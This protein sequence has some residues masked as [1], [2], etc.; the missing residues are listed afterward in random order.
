MTVTVAREAM[1]CDIFVG[2]PK[3]KAH[4]QM[5]MTLAVKNIF[6]IVKGVQQGNAAYAARLNAPPFCRDDL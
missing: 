2:L 4:N 3:I 6:G 1:E 5:Y